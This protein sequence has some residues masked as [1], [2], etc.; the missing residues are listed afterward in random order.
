MTLYENIIRRSS[1]LDKSDGVQNAYEKM[2]MEAKGPMKVSEFISSLESAIKKSFPKSLVR[3]QA[4][5]NLG[6]SIGVTFALGK[7]KS[8]WANGIIHNDPLHHVLM[9]GWNEFA[10]DAFL[11]DKITLDKPNIGGSL[12][13]LPEEGSYMAFGRVKLG[14]RKKTAPPEGIVKHLGNYFKK[15]KGILKDNIDRLTDEDR[16]IAKKK[17]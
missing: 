3:V 4:S 5:K 10:E 1:S 8:E 15:V 6:S 11:K 14:F 9:I 12:K 16:I 7:D 17:I 13:V 2:L